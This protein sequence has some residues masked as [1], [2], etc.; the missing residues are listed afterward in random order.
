[1]N[2][3]RA[4]RTHRIS[5]KCIAVAARRGASLIRSAAHWRSNPPLL[6]ST[7]L[8]SVLPSLSSPFLTDFHNP[9]AFSSVHPTCPARPSS[10]LFSKEKDRSRQEGETEAG[11]RARRSV[12]PSLARLFGERFFPPF[13]HAVAFLLL[14]FLLLFLLLVA[15]SRHESRKERTCSPTSSWNLQPPGSP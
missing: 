6:S 3:S 13:R 7:A 1:M 10:R 8:L 9:P 4:V 15:N 2:I 14:L 11:K 12:Y 5:G